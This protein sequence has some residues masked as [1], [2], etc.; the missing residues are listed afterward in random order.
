M[1]ARAL[2]HREEM[3][4]DLGISFEDAVAVMSHTWGSWGTRVTEHAAG[5]NHFKYD[6]EFSGGG[7]IQTE[8]TGF[9]NNRIGWPEAAKRFKRSA[10][11]GIHFFLIGL[12]A[13]DIE[14]EWWY[15][16]PNKTL[17]FVSPDGKKPA[18]GKTR[19]KRRDFQ[20]TAS[21][22]EHLHVKG[23]E[24]NGGAAWLD[25]C[26]N[27]RLE[28]CNFRF[29]A[30]HKFCIGNFDAPVTT[31]ISNKRSTN[32]EKRIYGNELINCQF[33]YQ[34]GN[35]FEG[36]SS[37]LSIDNVLIY[38]TQQTTLGL[39]SRSM[40]VDRPLLVRRVTIEEV[41]ASVGIKG[42]G[43][44]SVYELNNIARFGGLQYD[45]ASLQMGGREKFIYRFN[46]SHDHPKR[47]YRFDAG[48]YPDSANAFGEMSYN[49]AWNTPS[50]FA[51]KG[52][53]HLIHNNVLIGDGGFE[54][55]NMKR[56][57]SKNER[58]LVANNIVPRM[59][60]GGYDWDQPV[61]KKGT[62]SNQVETSDDFWLNETVVPKTHPTSVGKEG[63]AFDDGTKRGKRQSPLLAIRKNNCFE[64]AA[65]VLRDPAN[66][67]FRLKNETKLID[68]GYRITKRDVTWKE[69][70]I[71][72]SDLWE[73]EPDVGAYEYGS[74][75]YWIPGFKFPQASTS[76][77]PDGTTTAKSDCSLMWLGGYKAQNH[78]LYRGVSKREVRQAEKSD[79]AYRGTFEGDRNI[80]QFE[81]PLPAGSTIYWRV[82]AERDGQVV[83]G[84][85]WKFTV[86]K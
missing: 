65:Q 35:A 43:I 83:K 3:L 50:G 27:S 36:R 37:G 86:G 54:L 2:K 21:N 18:T 17:Y 20:L 32:N 75:H 73:A 12:P 60:A 4:G 7:A 61:V 24:F 45:G 8:A 48:S 82:D 28:D 59:S 58:T 72:G 11:S 44:D 55:F 53:D 15:H 81:R 84:Q 74:S 67:D 10:H 68:N 63:T 38:R 39:D 64:D 13:L 1:T 57:A 23:L 34:D 66:L 79:R 6:I 56:W 85:V 80:Y 70:A 49:V 22:C 33:T 30:M 5:S 78:H 42:G 76:I 40:S 14:E 51:I 19:G 41:G 29:A 77:P 62:S 25:E 31:R 71:T 16:K 69:V 26:E 46:W 52:D 9:L 47:S